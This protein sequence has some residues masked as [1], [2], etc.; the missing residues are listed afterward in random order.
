[1]IFTLTRRSAEALADPSPS[2]HRRP[3]AASSAP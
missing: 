2:P 1:M 3:T